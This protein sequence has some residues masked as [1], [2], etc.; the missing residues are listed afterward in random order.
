[1][2]TFESFGS[3]LQT[4]SERRGA[5]IARATVWSES[6]FVRRED[7]GNPMERSQFA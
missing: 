1:M 3:G 4:A 2:K 6:I 5:V 7:Q